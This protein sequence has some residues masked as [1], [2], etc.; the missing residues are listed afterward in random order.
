MTINYIITRIG[1]LGFYERNFELPE[2]HIPNFKN[3]CIEINL[4]FSLKTIFHTIRCK[5]NFNANQLF[6][7][8]DRFNS[9]K[10]FCYLTYILFTKKKQNKKRK[11]LKNSIILP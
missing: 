6:A 8:I 9:L 11:N 1:C 2:F 4:L 5:D 3:V 7:K 10:L